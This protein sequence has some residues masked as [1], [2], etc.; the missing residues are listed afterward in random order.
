MCTPCTF[1]DSLIPCDFFHKSSW[2]IFKVPLLFT[3][4]LLRKIFGL[5]FPFKCLDFLNWNTRFFSFVWYQWCF[6]FS[7]NSLALMWPWTNLVLVDSQSFLQ[8]HQSVQWPSVTLL[9]CCYCWLFFWKQM[10]L[11]SGGVFKFINFLGL[12]LLLFLLSFT[13]WLKMKF[14]NIST[15]NSCCSK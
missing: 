5:F 11:T 2:P 1:L 15:D 14:L 7:R 4:T 8:R 9:G 10:V 13:L 3:Q 12:S 6:W